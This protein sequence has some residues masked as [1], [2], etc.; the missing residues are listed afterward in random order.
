MALSGS[1][2]VLLLVAAAVALIAPRA[3]IPYTVALVVAGL[4]LGFVPLLHPPP[5]TKELLF[6][7]FLPGLLFEASVQL[8]AQEFWRNRVVIFSLAL[9][10]VVLS[11][12]IVASALVLLLPYAGTAIGWGAA[13]VFATLIA[14]TDPIA[15]VALVRTLGAPVRLAVLIEGE[16]LLNDGTAAVSFATALAFVLGAEPNAGRLAI[17]F[18]YA[19]LIAIVLGGGVGLVTRALLAWLNDPMVMIT[20]TTAAAY[21]SFLI[22]EDMHA[23]GVIAAVTAGLLSGSEAAKRAIAPES[24]AVLR[25]FW[26][27]I[28][29]AL[30]SIVFLL[31]GFQAGVGTLLSA[32]R[33]IVAAFLIVTLTRVVVTYAVV[34]AVS[35][36]RTFPPRWTPVLAWSGLRGSLAMVLAL[37]LPAEM[38]HRDAIVK[39]TIGVVMLSI[40]VQGTTVRPL[41]R[42]LGLE[43]SGEAHA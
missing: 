29:F 5:L 26:D 2:I 19:I 37:S 10:A 16:S 21:G 36:A 28:A 41:L 20:I 12:V 9:P 17:D 25:A 33:I 23:S 40:L 22:A 15:V 30:N 34:G 6:T 24:R 27:Y 39:M 14:A 8:E 1:I 18:I 4:L 31:I 43:R 32:W 35:N 13:F 11:T 7:V 3:R 42:R 38:V